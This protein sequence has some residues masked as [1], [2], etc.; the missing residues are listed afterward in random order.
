MTGKQ[1]PKGRMRF[2][3]LISRLFL[4]GIFTY[5][6]FDKILHPFEFAEVVYNYQL[7][8]DVLVNLVALFLPWIELLVGLSLILGVWLPGAV[9]ICNLLL[10]VFFSTLVFNIARGLDI[11]C[12]CFTL[13]V[14]T[15]SGG[16]M[17]WY[18][19]RDGFFLFVGLFLFFS[20][21]FM[22]N[23]RGSR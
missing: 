13:S 20:S 6:S 1:E 22:R 15:S 8:P 18:L 23:Q 12:G 11:D 4:G 5:A 2:H 9:L 16:H 7:L 17:L 14:G 21:F 19:F 10:M 3:L